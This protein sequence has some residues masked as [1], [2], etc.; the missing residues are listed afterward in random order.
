MV[1]LFPNG[2]NQIPDTT[3]T[4]QD[5]HMPAPFMD[6]GGG[7][8]GGNSNSDNVSNSQQQAQAYSGLD[9]F[10]LVP[11]TD[12]CGGIQTA[13]IFQQNDYVPYHQ[14]MCFRPFEAEGFGN[15]VGEMGTINSCCYAGGSSLVNANQTERL[16]SLFKSVAFQT[17][18]VKPTSPH[19]IR[20]LNQK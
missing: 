12:Y 9:E 6:P 4:A 11:P 10:P 8:G 20:S 1:G 7:G 3:S 5:I 19:P 14:A 13:S 17:S 18:D 15:A 2:N 16:G